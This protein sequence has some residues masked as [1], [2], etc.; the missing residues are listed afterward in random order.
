MKVLAIMGSHRKGR[1]TELALDTFLSGLPEDVIIDKEYLLGKDI[2]VCAAC[3]YCENN[4]AKCVFNDD[5]TTL[6]E[7]FKSADA[8]VFASPVYFNS[9]TTLM[10]I[11]IDRVQMIFAC[12][13]AFK[14]SFV[15]KEGNKKKGYLISLGGARKYEKQ[16]IGSDISMNLVFKDIHADFSGHFQIS[17]TDRYPLEGRAS[18]L[19]ALREAG[20]NFL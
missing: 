16:F 8:I 19:E 13:F 18:D 20:K 1:N 14:K 17:E 7:K 12:D 4:Y 5:M 15:S 11:M 10:K 9:V 3:G 6:Y 2:K